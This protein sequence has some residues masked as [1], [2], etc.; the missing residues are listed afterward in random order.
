MPLPKEPVVLSVDQI[1]ELNRKLSELRHDVNNGLSLMVAAAE[2][3]QRRPES[4]ERMWPAL[5]D[6]PRKIADVLKQ[7]SNDFE[8]ALHITR[9]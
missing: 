3:I 2:L 1:E 5:L 9:L 8:S 7:F 4:A 6:Q